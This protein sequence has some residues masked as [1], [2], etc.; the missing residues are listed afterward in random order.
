MHIIRYLLFSAACLW[1]ATLAAQQLSTD[2]LSSWLADQQYAKINALVDTL[3]EDSVGADIAYINGLA[4]FAAARDSLALV[5]F[6]YA[7]TGNSFLAGPY[8]YA[9]LLQ[10]VEGDLTTALPYFEAAVKND[11]KNAAYLLA[12]ADVYSGLGWTDSTYRILELAAA[13]PNAPAR[14]FMQLAEVYRG[15]GAEQRALSIYYDCLYQADPTSDYYDDCLYNVGFYELKANQPE[16]AELALRTL[17]SYNP[18]DYAAQEL[19]IQ[20]LVRQEN[21]NALNEASGQLYAYHKQDSLPAYMAQRFQFDAFQWDTL[22]VLVYEYFDEPDTGYTKLAFWVVNDSSEVLR[23]IHV[24]MQPAIA[25]PQTYFIVD[26]TDPVAQVYTS[27]SMRKNRLNYYALRQW[28]MDIL[29]GR[30]TADAERP[31]SLFD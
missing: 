4:H 8:Y 10:Q 9:G 27:R 1:S 28:V 14:V 30:I 24:V 13:L 31:S 29:Q 20:A 23:K 26:V 11:N 2:T 12:L 25:G 21:V 17:L 19:L 7:I 15:V 16:Q 6:E 18:R 3:S 22:S 5:W